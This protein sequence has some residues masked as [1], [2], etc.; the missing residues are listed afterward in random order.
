M[1]I[2]EFR[3]R[4][5]SFLSKEEIARYDLDFEPAYMNAEGTTKDD[6]CEMLKDKTVRAFVVQISKALCTKDTVKEGAC[7]ERERY[8]NELQSVKNA[9]AEKIYELEQG[10]KQ[11]ASTVDRV[12]AAN[13]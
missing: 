13:L 9:N 7:Q 5:E 2:D 12:L 8:R 11:I 6:F 1:N 4:T 3:N 10:L